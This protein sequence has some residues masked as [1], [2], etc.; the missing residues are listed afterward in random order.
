MVF[1][2]IATTFVPSA[3]LSTGPHFTTP[4]AIAPLDTKIFSPSPSNASKLLRA[5]LDEKMTHKDI[6][7]YQP[8]PHFSQMV[9]FNG[10]VYLAGQV[11][12]RA[13]GDVYGQTEQIL[14]K[15]DRLL[16]E[17]GTEKSRVISATV[18]MADIQKFAEMNRAWDA[19][20]DRDNMPVRATVQSK[21]A[22]DDLEVEIQVTAALPSLAKTIET[23]EA[24]EAV[25]PYNQGIM[26][27]DG[28]IY[29]SGCIGLMPGSGGMV[30]GGVQAQT[31]QA[32][33]NVRAVLA[34][35]GAQPTD[36]VK[37][38]I[39]L[40]DMANFAMVNAIYKEFFEGGRVPARSCFA[41]KQLPKG[42]LVEIEAIASLPQL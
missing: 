33:N 12:K 7:R 36:V 23:K 31:K 19:W 22:S 11:A 39:L 37:T 20:M 26:I 35:V 15:I 28:T 17:A 21:L 38:T 14:L 4:V 42:A 10:L 27:D 13:P 41:A 29:V 32:L 3:V 2:D 9:K 40:D 30:E 1:H 8:G 6:K 34:K 25:G 16:Q 5:I 24:A 18:W